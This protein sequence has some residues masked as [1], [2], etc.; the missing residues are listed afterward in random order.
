MI[1]TELSENK[2]KSN[3]SK[4]L[5][6]KLETWWISSS[7]IS[8]IIYRLAKTCLRKNYG[9]ECNQLKCFTEKLSRLI[10][11]LKENSKK[12]SSNTERLYYKFLLKGLMDYQY[13]KTNERKEVCSR[14]KKYKKRKTRKT[15][16]KKTTSRR[17]TKN[18]KT[19]MRRRKK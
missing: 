10:N 19:N 18:K 7:E 12:I 9:S 14:K 5:A 11:R 2:N 6:K 17:K 16:T 15:K 1:N 3:S 13:I 4:T 8:E